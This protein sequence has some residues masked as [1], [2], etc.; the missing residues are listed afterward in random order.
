MRF[1]GVRLVTLG[2]SILEYRTGLSTKYVLMW[3]KVHRRAYILFLL[4]DT[5]YNGG[6]TAEV[7]EVSMQLAIT[8]MAAKVNVVSLTD[9]ALPAAET[10]S[11]MCC[12][13]CRGRRCPS[14]YARQLRV[15]R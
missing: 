5:V 12:K 2:L 11:K 15:W 8:C 13:L 3:C 14:R 10:S 6:W 7:Y 9:S 4:A 1:S